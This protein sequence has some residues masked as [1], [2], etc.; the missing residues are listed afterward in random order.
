MPT[1]KKKTWTD[2]LTWSNA[3][4]LIVM[5]VVAWF[6]YAF[7]TKRMTETTAGAGAILWMGVGTQLAMMIR[8][9]KKKPDA[10]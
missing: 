3:G 10:E 9:F 1:R 6:A 8:E 2:Y 7:L 4:L 5:P